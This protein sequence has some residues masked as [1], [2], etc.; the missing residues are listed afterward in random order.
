MI[1]IGNDWD[2]Y[3]SNEYSKK[4]FIS[5]SDFLEEEYANK[6]IF[7]K[8]EDIFNALKYTS[9]LDTK[10]VILGQDPY[11]NEGEAHGLSFSVQEGIKVPPSLKNIF[12]EIQDDL[13]I[14]IFDTSKGNLTKWAKEGVLLL[15]T[16]LTVEKG[17]SNSHSKIGWETFTDEIIK[18]LNKKETPIVFMLWGNNAK[19]KETLIINKHHLVL[20]AIHPSPLGRGGFFGCKHFSLANDFLLSNNLKPI[21]WTL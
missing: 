12:K 11:I 17:V 1:K 16:T 2:T 14:S 20:K 7:P 13:S 18:I 5:M 10:V 3:L 19:K 21:D 8:K 9:F 4:Y 15:N 6:T